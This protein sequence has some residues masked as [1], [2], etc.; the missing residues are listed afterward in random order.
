MNLLIDLDEMEDELYKTGKYIERE[1]Y[2]HLHPKEE[3]INKIKH[4]MNTIGTPRY[5]VPFSDFLAE[6]NGNLKIDDEIRSKYRKIEVKTENLEKS[7]ENYKNQI[8][9]MEKGPDFVRTTDPLPLM[10]TK[11]FYRYLKSIRYPNYFKQQL[12]K[13]DYEELKPFGV[14]QNVEKVQDEAIKEIGEDFMEELN[15]KFKNDEEVQLAIKENFGEKFHFKK[16]TFSFFE[17]NKELNKMKNDE[18]IHPKIREILSS[19]QESNL[20]MEKITFAQDKENIINKETMKCEIFESNGKLK[21][22]FNENGEYELIKSVENVFLIR[23]SLLN[24]VKLSESYNLR[25]NENNEIILSTCEF[26]DIKVNS[27][28]NNLKHESMINHLYKLN[29]QL[30]SS[31][32]PPKERK[33]EYSKY[34]KVITPKPEIDWPIDDK[35]DNSDFTLD[36]EKK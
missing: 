33:L 6:I 3:E 14:S 31:T 19:N 20:K 28:I 35:S 36:L 2:L 13:S 12:T 1:K 30:M 15:F 7:K 34:T 22:E 27:D 4:K 10:K 21:I 18:K 29:E 8:E 9:E 24:P 5:L 11:S 17:L 16:P 32:A 23:H 26:E 25:K